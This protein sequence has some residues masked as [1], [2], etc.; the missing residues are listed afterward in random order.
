MTHLTHNDAFSIEV[1]GPRG[2]AC[3]PL[4]GLS[5]AII[6]GIKRVKSEC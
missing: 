5:Y 1:S 4:L 3:V 6:Y 2:R